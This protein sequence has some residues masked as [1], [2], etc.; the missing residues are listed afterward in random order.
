MKKELLKKLEGDIGRPLTKQDRKCAVKDD[1]LAARA[2]AQ[3]NGTVQYQFKYV[4]QRNMNYLMKYIA[5]A[6]VA[7]VVCLAITLPIT[8]GGNPMRIYV[9]I[10]PPPSESDRFVEA[11]ITVLQ[12]SEGH[13]RANNSLLF[14]D[15]KHKAHWGSSLIE[16]TRN[17][18]IVLSY[19][20]G[21]SLL[22]FLDVEGEDHYWWMSKR[23]RTQQSYFF[24]RWEDFAVLEV[25]HRLHYNGVN[26]AN[27]IYS[28]NINTEVIRPLVGNVDGILNVSGSVN[29]FIVDGTKIFAQVLEEQCSFDEN[30]TNVR[31]R[32]YFRH[33]INEYFLE[34]NNED[35][36]GAPLTINHVR[37][38][39]MPALMTS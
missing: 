31:V 21:G 16:L 33:G 3:I 24:D 20:I 17:S 37:N 22:E 8:L 35:M 29:A 6:F 30:I 14:F 28:F 12:M 7:V 23:I 15:S 34:I 27:N 25:A 1:R 39:I 11:D 9:P 13:M 5:T 4:P 26:S 19:L 2:Q 38:I 32:L 18:N 36:Y 10:G